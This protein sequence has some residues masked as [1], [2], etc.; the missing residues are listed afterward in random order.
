MYLLFLTS[1]H[2]F[3]SSSGYS[4]PSSFEQLFLPCSSHEVCL[5]AVN[6]ST[7][8]PSQAGPIPLPHLIKGPPVCP[9]NGHSQSS[10]QGFFWPTAGVVRRIVVG[11]WKGVLSSLMMKFWVHETREADSHVAWHTEKPDQKQTTMKPSYQRRDGFQQFL[12]LKE[13]P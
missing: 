4:N 7:P 3:S 1:Q 11:K 6:H 9:G 12:G 2:F 8:L 13:L 10:F 5:E